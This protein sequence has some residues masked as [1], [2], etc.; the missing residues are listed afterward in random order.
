MYQRYP[1]STKGVD[2][3]RVTAPQSIQNAVKL[4]YAGA[5]LTGISIIVLIVTIS[6]VKTA[7]HKANPSWTTHHVSTVATSYVV[8][9][10]VAG[11]IGVGLWI[12]MAQMNGKGRQRA[13][14]VATILFAINTLSI[15]QLLRGGATVFG[16]IMVVLTWL[17]GLGAVVLLWQ[18]NS[19]EYYNRVRDAAAA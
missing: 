6:Q 11:L 19:T 15:F 2:A 14:M 12:M 9:N 4:M 7:F 8:T 10:I 5:V 17:A 16:V 18:S 3:D 13:R 1:S